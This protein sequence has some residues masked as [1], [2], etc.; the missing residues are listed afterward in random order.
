MMRVRGAME[1]GQEGDPLPT[2]V[3]AAKTLRV[4]GVTELLVDVDLGYGVNVRRRLFVEGFDTV[5]VSVA[6]HDRAVRCLALLLGGRR[7]LVQTS[8]FDPDAN[9]RV[10]VF[11]AERTDSGASW[12]AVPHGMAG[13]YIDVGEFFRWL[14]SRG[15]NADDVKARGREEAGDARVEHA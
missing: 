6:D 2:R 10:R 15:F 11:L 13:H 4:V 14:A 5:R 3:Y 8:S 9:A 12:S 7:L 1:T